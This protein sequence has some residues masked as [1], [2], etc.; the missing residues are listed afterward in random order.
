MKVGRGFAHATT[1]EAVMV[2]VETVVVTGVA[3]VMVVWQVITWGR[4]RVAC[5]VGVEDALVLRLLLWK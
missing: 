5:E 2:V 1:E 4:S 3:A